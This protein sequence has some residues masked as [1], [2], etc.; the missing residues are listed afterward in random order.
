[1]ET[2]VQKIRNQHEFHFEINLHL[3]HNSDGKER[4]YVQEINLSLNTNHDFQHIGNIGVREAR[5]KFNVPR[6]R[7]QKANYS[8]AAWK[9]DDGCS[10]SEKASKY[11]Q[12]NL[13]SV[14]LK[15]IGM[16]IARGKRRINIDARAFACSRSK[17]ISLSFSLSLSFSS[18]FKEI[19]CSASRRADDLGT[20]RGGRWSKDWR[21]Q[22]AATVER[23][24]LFAQIF[25]T[26]TGYIYIYIFQWRG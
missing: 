7:K 15:C 9:I 16:L 19:N 8:L 22:G 18:R 23:L 6:Q 14:A 11:Y 10:V 24:V 25:P 26:K 4:G 12:Q 17:R 1:M 21:N 20:K 5:P 13:H 2:R 3:E